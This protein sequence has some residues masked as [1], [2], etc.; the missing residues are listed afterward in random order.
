MGVASADLRQLVSILSATL[1][2]TRE[3]HAGAPLDEAA[4][5][6]C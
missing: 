4:Q 3:R 6:E 1:A 5:Q 2:T